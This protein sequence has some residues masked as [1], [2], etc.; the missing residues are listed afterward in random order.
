MM[1]L[2]PTHSDLTGRAYAIYRRNGSKPGHEKDDWLQA[3]YELLRQPLRLLAALKPSRTQPGISR[4]RTLTD[5]VRAKWFA[6]RRAVPVPGAL[7]DGFVKF[8]V[9]L[10]T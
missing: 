3:E 8:P 10:T 6:P 7:P 2:R 1:L 4:I 9:V 5:L